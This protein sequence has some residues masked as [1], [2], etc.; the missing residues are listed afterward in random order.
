VNKTLRELRSWLS[1]KKDTGIF[2]WKKERSGRG[3]NKT[4]KGSRAG[5]INSKGYINIT[6][7]GK[8]YKAHRI[9]WAFFYGRFPAGQIDH[10]NGIKKD[11]RIENL[12]DCST[13][14]N[15]QNK[16]IHRSGR[17]VG[18]TFSKT[19][20]KWI[21]QIRIRGKKVRLGSFESE[22]EAHEKYIEALKK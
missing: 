14:Q 17:L 20:N 8:S 2:V 5:S 4:K 18:T 6:F 9:A 21:S 10:I 16:V 19:Q 1:Y 3:R 7:F 15:C 13:Q 12:R 11:N 22:K